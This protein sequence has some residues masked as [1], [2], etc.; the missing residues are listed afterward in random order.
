MSVSNIEWTE[1]TWN[2]ITGCNKVSPGCKNCY[3]E[4]F[5]KR[6]KAMRQEKYKNGFQLTLHEN[7]LELPLSWKK[8]KIIFVNSMSDLFHEQ[9]SFDLIEKAF[10]VMR[11]ADW[12]QFQILTKR[13]ER[14][15][16]LANNISWPNN[17]WMGVSVETED[18]TERISHLLFTKAKVKFLSLEPLLGPLNNLN[19]KGIDWVVV[20]GES[21]PK[22]RPIEKEWVVSIKNQCLENKVP[23]FFKQ[24]G[25]VNKK[26]NGRELDGKTWNDLPKIINKKGTVLNKQIT[27]IAV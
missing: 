9:V 16:E 18:Y 5:S 8:P 27:S 23:F 17:V 19:L 2:F 14:L 6:L 25:G 12:H 1:F 13:S 10:N 26:K 15:L 4:S 11:K 20:G 21:G 3:A 7:L 24:W 22:S